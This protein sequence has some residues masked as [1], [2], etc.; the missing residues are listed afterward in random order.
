MFWNLFNAVWMGV[1]TLVM[2]KRAKFS[3]GRRMMYIPLMMCVVELMMANVLTP[4]L[5]P[6]L[7][8]ILTVARLAVTVCCVG[9]LRREAAYMKRR[10][11]IR[12]LARQAE[13][14]G[15]VIPMFGASAKGR[16][17]VAFD[18]EKIAG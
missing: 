3:V 10:A 5:A 12:R 16:V 4:G 8:A 18:A 17:S 15:L 9:E 1:L 13:N 6:V 11:R 14:V 7:T 2:A